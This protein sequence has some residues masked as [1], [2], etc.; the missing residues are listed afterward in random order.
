MV[1]EPRSPFHGMTHSNAV[2]INETLYNYAVRFTRE[3]DEQPE[4]ARFKGMGLPGEYPSQPMMGAYDLDLEFSAGH[5]RVISPSL[6]R[7][8]EV[9]SRS[10]LLQCDACGHWDEPERM[11]EIVPEFAEPGF[12]G[13]EMFCRRSNK[14]C[15]YWSEDY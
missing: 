1:D 7:S 6:V 11:I 5:H 13:W 12:S 8:F 2:L 10:R 3:R 15:I 4:E 14:P 9:I